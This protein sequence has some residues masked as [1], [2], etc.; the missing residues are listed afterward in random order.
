MTSGAPSRLGGSQSYA[1][2]GSMADTSQFIDLI[3]D[4]MKAV[5]QEIGDLKQS[6][7]RELQAAKNQ[8][9]KAILAA[10]NKAIVEEAQKDQPAMLSTK[11]LCVGCGRPSLVRGVPFDQSLTNTNKFNPSLNGHVQPGP[12]IYRGGF[13]MPVSRNSLHKIANNPLQPGTRVFNEDSLFGDDDNDSH[14]HASLSTYSEILANIDHRDGVTNMTDIGPGGMSISITSTTTPIRQMSYPARKIAHAQGKEE[15][16]ILRPIHRKGFPGKTSEKARQG[17]NK[18]WA[19]ERLGE[20]LSLSP[21]A[22]SIPRPKM[23]NKQVPTRVVPPS[24]VVEEESAF[25]P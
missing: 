24:I 25:Q 11:A 2:T 10:I 9:R 8:M 3:Q 5:S 1:G 21:S 19:P 16:A 23:V 17:V 12:D 18:T 13:K 15:A 4:S 7:Q 20:Q 6:S 22:I 14:G